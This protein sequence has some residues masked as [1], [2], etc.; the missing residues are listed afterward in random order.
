[1][2]ALVLSTKLIST[3]R[4]TH[5]HKPNFLKDYCKTCSVISLD[6]KQWLDGV[7]LIM[8]VSFLLCVFMC[9]VLFLTYGQ[10]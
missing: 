9:I 4:N 3:K 10:S 1:M 6:Y 5:K 2:I 7:L 8:C